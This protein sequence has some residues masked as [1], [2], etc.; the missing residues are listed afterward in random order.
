M[1][2]TKTNHLIRPRTG[3][4]LDSGQEIERILITIF[5]NLSDNYLLYTVRL[6]PCWSRM[7]PDV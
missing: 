1:I 5:F 6:L 7:K 3:D 4:H 2:I